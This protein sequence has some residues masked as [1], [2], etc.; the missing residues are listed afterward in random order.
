MAE[1][2]EKSLALFRIFLSIKRKDQT[3]VRKGDLVD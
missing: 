3:M 2:L 1:L